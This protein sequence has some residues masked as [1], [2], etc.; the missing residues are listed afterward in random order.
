MMPDKA[1][2]SGRPLRDATRLSGLGVKRPLVPVVLALMVGLVAGAWGLRIPGVWLAA[3]LAGLLA[4]LVLLRGGGPVPGSKGQDR[5]GPENPPE[6]GP[7]T[8]PE[9]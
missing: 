1:A 3:G 6:P 2:E 7:D 8:S 9:S 4:L 5:Q